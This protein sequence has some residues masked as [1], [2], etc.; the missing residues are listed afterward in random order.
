MAT[1]EKINDAS[2]NERRA[3][4]KA[5]VAARLGV[6]G[7]FIRVPQLAKALGISSTSIHSQIRRGKFPILHR[8]VG[9]V[10]LVKLDDYLSWFEG[11]ESG[12]NS[13]DGSCSLT[14]N[15]FEHDRPSTPR[16]FLENLNHRS[17][18]TEAEFKARISH[19]VLA[20]MRKKGFD[21]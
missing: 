5:M 14:I 9:N 1:P 16:D 17:R 19:E 20:D 21:V 4:L 15:S 18:P 3:N 8:R 12:V 13:D 11:D 2:S 7:E 6:K 10:I